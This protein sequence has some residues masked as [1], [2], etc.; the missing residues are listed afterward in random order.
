MVAVLYIFLSSLYKISRIYT[1]ILI[2]SGPR[3]HGPV[4]EV[5]GPRCHGPVTKFVGVVPY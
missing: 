2:I 5:R 4:T 3:C 1:L